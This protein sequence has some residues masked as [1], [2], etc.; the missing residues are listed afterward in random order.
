MGI[1]I[2]LGLAW[3]GSVGYWQYWARTAKRDERWN[4]WQ[5]CRGKR[6]AIL[7]W[8]AA[9]AAVAVAIYFS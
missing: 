2:L 3:L 8:T 7:G 5:Y 1:L 6:N 9:L 4:R